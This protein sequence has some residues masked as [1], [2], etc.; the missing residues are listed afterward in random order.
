MKYPLDKRKLI[1][2]YWDAQGIINSKSIPEFEF[3]LFTKTCKSMG[4]RGDE[5]TLSDFEDYIDWMSEYS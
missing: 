2:D 4:W 1:V 3:D 5:L